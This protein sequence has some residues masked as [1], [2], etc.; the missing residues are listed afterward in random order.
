MTR[1]LTCPW[2]INASWLQPGSCPSARMLTKQKQSLYKSNDYGSLKR[3]LII[4]NTLPL[5]LRFRHHAVFS[6]AL[7]PKH[8]ARRRWPFPRKPYSGGYCSCQCTYR[9]E[10][11]HRRPISPYR[12]TSVIERH[13]W[14]WTS[15]VC[16]ISKSNITKTVG[17]RL[18]TDYVSQKYVDIVWNSRAV[19]GKA[20]TTIAGAFLL[21]IYL[22]LGPV[23]GP[24]S[25]CYR[26]SWQYP[27]SYAW[28]ILIQFRQNRRTGGRHDGESDTLLL[29]VPNCLSF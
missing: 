17:R 4:I 15:P 25:N 10:Q 9:R 18:P 6:T 14:A 2:I 3:C 28:W 8:S 23:V 20:Q 13:Q 19:A 22:N 21:F 11:R 5:A 1:W 16:G 26:F 12:Q 27:W 29:F 24:N 7:L